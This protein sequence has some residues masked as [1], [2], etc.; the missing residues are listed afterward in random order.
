[1]GCL[2]LT[3]SP[4]VRGDWRVLEAAELTLIHHLCSV[5]DLESGELKR[6]LKG[7]TDWVKC[8]AV[9]PTGEGVISG[10]DDKTVR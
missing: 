6:M 5:W 4:I 3:D 7:H 8:V 1:M 9:T 10:S 2:S